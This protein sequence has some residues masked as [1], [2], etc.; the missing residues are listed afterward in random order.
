M[1]NCHVINLQ[2][3]K[4]RMENFL[5]R[6]RL[7]LENL[8][9]I[10]AVD[11]LK[12]LYKDFQNKYLVG[13]PE[14]CLDKP[15]GGNIATLLS[16]IKTWEYIAKHS[17]D[18]DINIVF[19]DDAIV[20]HKFKNKLAKF[21]KN[22][23][24]DWDFLY[25]YHNKGMD[26]EI[27]EEKGYYIPNINF[28]SGVNNGLVSYAITKK[29]AQKF[30]ELIKPIDLENSHKLKYPPDHLVKQYWNDI[31]VYFVIENIVSHDFDVKSERRIKR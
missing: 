16:H 10:D 18:N 3:S 26:G 21:I 19:E 14:N 12:K 6:N 22:I 9:R 30:V 13:I 4:V 15:I 20:P 29:G 17:G 8:N 7:K 11:G 5:K 23:P 27:V 1:M 28:E 25:L 31:R 24:E 2:R